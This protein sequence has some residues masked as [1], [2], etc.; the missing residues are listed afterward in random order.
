MSRA[1]SA[2]LALLGRLATTASAGRGRW[3]ATVLAM[4]LGCVGACVLAVDDDTPPPG[5][6]DQVECSE[7]AYCLD[8]ECSC[9]SGYIGDPYAEHGCELPAEDSPCQTTCGLNAYCEAG[10]CVCAEGFAAVCG[11]AD[12]MALERICDGI[13]DCIG[14]ADEE[15]SLCVPDRV[16][17]FEV[18]D[19]CDD[20]LEAQWRLWSDRRDWVWP[21]PEATFTTAGGTP[22]R[23]AI[24]CV[25]GEPV[26][27]GAAAGD[28]VWGVGIERTQSCDDCCFA[29]ADTTVDVGVLDCP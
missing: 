11:N 1:A 4:P 3:A 26:C 24:E 25:D 7:N 5:P 22:V 8:G 10:E 28:R 12:C 13:D 21:S 27:F 16:M 2:L 23:E 15:A 14:G 17:T 18:S 20:G 29:C 19:G 6:C 9:Q